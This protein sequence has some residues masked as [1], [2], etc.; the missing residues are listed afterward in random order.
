[1][2]IET[3]SRLDRQV[4]HVELRPSQIEIF[5]QIDN[6]I[7]NRD[8]VVK[9]N[10]GGGKTTTGLIYLKHMMDKYREP[11]VFLVPTIQLAEQVVEEGAKIGLDVHIWAA[12]ESYPPEDCVQCAAVMVCTYD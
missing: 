11:V 9:L 10:T 12:K 1:S 7:A 2:L 4:S 3:F 5:R 8:L 6:N